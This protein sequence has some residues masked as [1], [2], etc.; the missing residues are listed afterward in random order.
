M[1]HFILEHSSNILE[2]PV[3]T[4]LLRSLHTLLV[5]CGPFKLEDIK[6][7]VHCHQVY[8]VADG[9]SDTAFV[10]LQLALLPGRS[11]D[12]RR[13]VS[14]RLLE[15]LKRSFSQSLESLC[16]SLTVE[17][18]ELDKNTYQKFTSGKL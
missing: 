3:T 5:D 7:R 11:E 2:S 10:H 15:F 4:D 13:S 16:C 9:S 14:E 8:C 18:R 12:I 6:S 17:L 1:P